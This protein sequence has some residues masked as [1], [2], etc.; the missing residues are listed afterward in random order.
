MFGC[1]LESKLKAGQCFIQYE[2]LQDDG[3]KL[4]NRTFKTVVGPVVITKN[5]W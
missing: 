3:Q 2:L 4:E 5:P 1:T